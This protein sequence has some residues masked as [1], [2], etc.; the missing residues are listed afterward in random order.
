VWL[1]TW[2]ELFEVLGVLDT[3][4]TEVGALVFKFLL[5]KCQME[6]EIHVSRERA[7]AVQIAKDMLLFYGGTLFLTYLTSPPSCCP[8]SSALMLPFP[9][10]T[11]PEALRSGIGFSEGGLTAL[12]SAPCSTEFIS[13][14]WPD[15]LIFEITLDFKNL[16]LRYCAHFHRHRF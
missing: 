1:S 12:C 7:L 11:L 3:L 5:R 14:T 16:Q 4:L 10:S 6:L 8:A 15:S 13:L 2:K 9:T